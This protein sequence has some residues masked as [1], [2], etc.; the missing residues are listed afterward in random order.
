[1][2]TTARS[3]LWIKTSQI[4]RLYSQQQHQQKS[5]NGQGERGS[6]LEGLVDRHHDVADGFEWGGLPGVRQEPLLATPVAGLNRDVRPP[7]EQV[8]AKPVSP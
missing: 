5:A 4:Q 3:S 2:Y 1:M 7:G 8:P 6:A